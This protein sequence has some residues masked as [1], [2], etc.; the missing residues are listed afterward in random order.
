MERSINQILCISMCIDITIGE[1][2]ITPSSGPGPGPAITDAEVVSP[3]LS[4][5]EP[6]PDV[7]LTVS[8]T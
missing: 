5:P 4:P 6:E 3:E 1:P 8:G 7:A 2:Y